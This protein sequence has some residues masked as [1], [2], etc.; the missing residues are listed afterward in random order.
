MISLV[1]QSEPPDSCICGIGNYRNQARRVLRKYNGIPEKQFYWFLKETEFKFNC[2]SHKEQLKRSNYGRIY[3]LSTADQKDK[4]EMVSKVADFA[5][6]M[7]RISSIIKAMIQGS[8]SL[9]PVYYDSSKAAIII[10]IYPTPQKLSQIHLAVSLSPVR[11]TS[12]APE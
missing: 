10:I 12:R 1:A 4:S 5:E 8:D 7:Q 2:G 9:K 3:S 6:Y 11:P